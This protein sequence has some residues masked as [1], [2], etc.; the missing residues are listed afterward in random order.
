MNVAILGLGVV[1][2]GVYDILTSDFNDI[3]VVSVLV[4]DMSKDRHISSLVTDDFT[5][6][7]LD[8]S[9]D[10]IIEVIG[11]TSDAFDYVV[12][13]L[14]AKKH[15]VTA[16]KALV[17]AHF[18]ELR[19]LADSNGVQFLYEASVG[20][21]IIVL[22]PLKTISQVNQL[23]KIQGIIN[24]ST[25]Y[26]LSKIFLEDYPLETALEEARSLG[27]IETGSSD[28]LEGWDLLRK[29]NILSM[30]TYHQYI[31]EE[32]IIRIPLMD[33]T[34]EFYDY[35]KS[36]G[37]LLKYIATSYKKEDQIQI[38]L[39]PVILGKLHPYSKIHYEENIITVS[40][41]YH[42]EQS[43]IGSGAG[44]YPT[45][46]AVIYDVLKI[47]E[48]KPTYIE[49][50]SKYRI[51][52]NLK[53]YHFLVQKGNQFIKTPFMTFEELL[54][55]NDILAIARIDASIINQI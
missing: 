42:E 44:S 41:K 39:E 28:D 24:G 19:N 46:S 38:H 5:K 45:A 37:F 14:K 49:F 32:D 36:K 17:S 16:N 8:D 51:N 4:K 47:S 9:I 10:T 1:G 2:K 35:V 25:N 40:G 34:E 23:D 43:F 30:I 7:L 12:A 33:I 6:I 26:I 22:D 13:S 50:S 53:K 27:Y 20:G 55:D 52:N 29:I 21:G 3:H 54:Q 48:N 11:G 15:V 31:Q 18:E